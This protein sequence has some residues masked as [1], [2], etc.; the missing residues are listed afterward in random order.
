MIRLRIASL[1]ADGMITAILGLG[2]AALL[3]ATAAGALQQSWAPM[4][5]AGTGISAGLLGCLGMLRRAA[6]PVSNPSPN[7]SLNPALAPAAPPHDTTTNS[8]AA[9]LHTM[10]EEMV[11]LKRDGAETSRSLADARRAS[12]GV[13]D[14]AG[15][16]IAW[17]N[18]SAESSALAA[19]ALCALP[20]I[21]DTYAQRIELMAARAEQVLDLVPEAIG[22]A[23]AASHALHEDILSSVQEGLAQH[24]P[25][26][27]A[28]LEEAI[29]RLNGLPGDVGAA[30]YASLAARQP[31]EVGALEGAIAR[32]EAARPDPMFAAG[33]IEATERL[34][35]LAGQVERLLGAVSGQEAGPGPAE[36]AERLHAMLA[37]SLGE[38]LSLRLIALTK[39][40]PENQAPG[41]EALADRV[42]LD[43]RLGALSADLAAFGQSLPAQIGQQLE[44]LLSGWTERLFQAV[45]PSSRVGNQ[46]NNVAARVEAA[47]ASIDGLCATL[48]EAV[49]GGITAACAASVG[50]F[51]DSLND[52]MAEL[53]QSLSAGCEARMASVIDR[54][55]SAAAV[56]PDAAEGLQSHLAALE[57]LGPV[58]AGVTERLIE[59][60]DALAASGSSLPP[61]A[62]AASQ[63]MDALALAGGEAAARG[64]PAAA[65]RPRD[66]LE[67]SPLHATP[68]AAGLG[69]SV[70]VATSILGQL[71][72]H[73]EPAMAETL[74]RLDGISGQV[75]A[76]LREAEGLVH[77]SGG[78]RISAS[79]AIRA[80]EVLDSLHE[81][82]RGLQSISTAIAIAADRDMG[83]LRSA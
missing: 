12:A 23:G 66:V 44:A 74:T 58:L 24:Q 81:T 48:P 11:R 64:G 4:V 46:M 83:Q 26:P 13:I 59:T 50:Q 31:A 60:A 38:A 63:T 19:R 3:A 39:A 29:A 54:L 56:F 14:V 27:V 34:A 10:A 47:A 1:G 82:I 69:Q 49:R 61:I 80:P 20:G 57:T 17:L 25:G 40:V 77:H 15:S 67:S 42:K 22:R 9:L 6:R 73:E 68:Q 72:K 32:L 70:S 71:A 76:M 51:E 5:A 7:P 36:L 8:I 62:P 18:E 79:V 65:S 37:P 21:A 35:S 75:A 45:E 16:T 33:L 55:D 28:G 2:A 30:I 78:R 43:T 53:P 41:T 52:L